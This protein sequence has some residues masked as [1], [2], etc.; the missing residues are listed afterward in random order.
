MAVGLGDANVVA[1][2]TGKG[3]G[4]FN[5]GVRVGLTGYS[6]ALAVGDLNGDGKPDLV[7]G[8]TAVNVVMNTSK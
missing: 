2:F 3:D 7:V 6:G 4:S 1:I 5:A 8:G